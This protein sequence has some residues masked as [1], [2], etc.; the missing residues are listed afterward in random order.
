MT[1]ILNLQATNSKDWVQS[2]DPLALGNLVAGERIYFAVDRDGTS[3]ASDFTEVTFTITLTSGAGG[4]LAAQQVSQ[5]NES[6]K[7]E[8]VSFYPNPVQ[9][10][11]Y[12]ND[13]TEEADVKIYN[14]M[15][16]LMQ[17]NKVDQ[18]NKSFDLTP[19]I[20]QYG[21]YLMSLETRG[22]IRYYKF[23]KE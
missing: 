6:G 16:T 11:V 2:P 3:Y 21:F 22:A 5:V 13:L 7:E 17:R 4:R 18:D 23:L 12:F 20:F 15:G 10:T 19:G 1:L 14:T 9:H 8:W